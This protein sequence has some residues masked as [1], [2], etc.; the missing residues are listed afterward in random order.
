MSLDH[1]T[2]L[3][4]GLMR[5]PG[6]LYDAA[7]IAREDILNPKNW[8]ILE[9]M[10][11]VAAGG[12]SVCP[13]RVQIELQRAAKTSPAEGVDI[14]AGL[15]ERAAGDLSEHI[16]RVLQAS[17]KRRAIDA[18]DR[19]RVEI[20]GDE[21]GAVDRAVSGLL[22]ATAP[23]DGKALA[24]EGEALERAIIEAI[25]A[26]DAGGLS[27]GFLG[28]DRLDVS[29]SPGK[30]IVLAAPTSIGK[31][32]MASQIAVS[33]AQEGGRALLGS[34]EM[35]KAELL[36]RMVSQVARIPSEFLASAPHE[37]IAD[38]ARR[39]SSSGLGIADLCGDSRLETLVSVAQAF[40]ARGGLDLLAIDYL[41]L[42]RLAGPR[43]SQYE[44]ISETTRAIKQLAGSL[45][46]GI[47]LLAQL[48]R[49]PS[50]REDSRPRLSDLRDSG[51]IEQDADVVLLIHRERGAIDGTLIVE[52]NRSG[53]KGDVRIMFDGPTCFFSEPDERPKPK[54]APKQTEIRL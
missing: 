13:E 16:E 41:G 29:I 50:A 23:R 26:D 12:S 15:V 54:P 17:L 43:R 47:L 49:Q 35:S 30:V 11:A 5:T 7:V 28:L 39:V 51:S 14:L 48:N 22:K 10:R 32:A 27:T 8:A 25:S 52:K 1:E 36:R 31:S 21:V 37:R 38:A 44:A 34:F 18:L 53:P 3:L 9:A 33:V 4:A 6:R 46:C 19:A 42:I 20:E 45:D 2:A 24:T 40:K